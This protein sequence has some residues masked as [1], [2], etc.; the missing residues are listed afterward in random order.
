MKQQK[1]PAL[2]M[3]CSKKKKKTKKQKQPAGFNWSRQQ[4]DEH[5]VNKH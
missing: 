1:A 4:T 5:I 3:S 2:R